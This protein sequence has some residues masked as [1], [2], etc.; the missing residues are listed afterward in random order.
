M[1]DLIVDTVN[2]K[3]TKFYIGICGGIWKHDLWYVY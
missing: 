2:Y 1:N 3:S